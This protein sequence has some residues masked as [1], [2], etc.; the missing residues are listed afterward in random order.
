MG[1]MEKTWG[2]FFFV[3]LYVFI[4]MYACVHVLYL[5]EMSTSGCCTDTRQ[6]DGRIKQ[7]KRPAAWC[8]PKM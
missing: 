2:L 4:R 8:C 7:H 6:E 5:C 1:K 3:V